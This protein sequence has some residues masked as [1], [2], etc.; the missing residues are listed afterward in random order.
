[1]RSELVLDRL[2]VAQDTGSAIVGPARADIFWGAGDEAGQVAA[3]LRHAGKFVMLVP[4]DSTLS[5][6]VRKCRFRVKGRRV[7]GERPLKFHRKSR[8]TWQVFGLQW[9]LRDWRLGEG[10]QC[11]PSLVR[12]VSR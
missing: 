7:L 4:R 5:L 11:Q 9:R 3:H 12:F 1:M 10:P 2:M 8:R 6:R